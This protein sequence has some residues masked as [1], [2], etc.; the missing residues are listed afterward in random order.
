MSSDST[1][2][3][4]LI[5]VL[6]F[7]LTILVAIA[8]GC[9][10]RRL[11]VPAGF[12]VGALVAVAAF[13]VFTGEAQY[14][15]WLKFLV[16]VVSGALIG[17]TV[18]MAD[19][20]GLKSL[21]LPAAVMIAGMLVVN[22]GMGTLIWYLS[23]MDIVTAL[24]GCVP[25]GVTETTIISG[26][27]GADTPVVALMQLVRF[28]SVMLVFPPLI[29]A[30][31]VR[32]SPNDDPV[33]GEAEKL[34]AQRKNHVG[35]KD[36]VITFVLALAGGVIGDLLPVPAGAL[37]FSLVVVSVYNLCTEKAWVHRNEKFAAQICCG[38]YIGCKVT[39]DSLLE[40]RSLIVPA[41]L[42]VVGFAVFHILLGVLL[43]KLFKLELPAMLF[44]CAPGGAS[45]MALI[46]GELSNDCSSIA[47]LQI[48]RLF[49]VIILFP[50]A[51]SLYSTLF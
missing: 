48:I 21:L 6:S 46:A 40:I 47:V 30:I 42:M 34:L 16:Q 29:K 14:Y 24:L 33:E 45:D 27:M 5:P 12:L 28:V 7:G 50:Q 36:L 20:R 35:A 3:R 17:S 37:I 44:A 38:A 19:I 25:G 9:L 49:F 13:N 10:A 26:D 11:K 4:R 32:Y 2:W 8:G 43:S 18:T 51:I 23:E 1:T 41:I 39:M 31:S 22:L 15:E